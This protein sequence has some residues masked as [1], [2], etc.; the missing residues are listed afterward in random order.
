MIRRALTNTGWLMGARGIN[1]VLSLGY[2]ALATRALGLEGFGKFVLAVSFA[3]AHHRARLVPDL[4]GGGA[5]G[6]RGARPRPTRSASRSRS[7]W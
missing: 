1:A 2:L 4:A 6:P 3:Q 7:T 5:L